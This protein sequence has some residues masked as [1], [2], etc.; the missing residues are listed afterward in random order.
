MDK[1][2]L[3]QALIRDGIDPTAYSL[4]GGLPSECY[5]LEQ[6]GHRWYVFYSE[7]GQRTGEREFDTESAAGAHLYDVLVEAVGRKQRP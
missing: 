1:A 4:E 3:G 2:T 6:R 5:V 7:R